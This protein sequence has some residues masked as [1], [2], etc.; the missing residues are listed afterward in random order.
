M[1]IFSLVTFS[2]TA[3][4]ADP[5]PPSTTPRHSDGFTIMPAY[6]NTISPRKFLFELK[7]GSS[8]SDYAYIKNLSD[9][10]THFL[11][12][13]ADATLSNQGTLAYKTRQS[14]N[15]GQGKWIQFDEPEIDL[16]PGEARIIKFTV[17]VPKGTTENTYKAGIAIEKSK[18]DTKN[19][20][21]IIA[22]RV[23][24]HSEIKVTLNPQPIPK[25]TGE[26]PLVESLKPKWQIYYFW[27][28]LA[29][30]LTSIGLL[31]WSTWKEK[32]LKHHSKK[33]PNNRAQ[34]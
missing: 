16:G 26:N 20:G 13:G 12:Y 19:A 27:I 24:L 23:I 1:I 4:A 28:S 15:N 7:P 3:I 30:F 33:P 18:K 25:E 29:L 6:P 21:V 22:S 8:T 2:A 32:N 5:T 10:E 14:E 17:T 34:T 11:L 31:G 9:Q